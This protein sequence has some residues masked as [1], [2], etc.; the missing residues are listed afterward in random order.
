LD[1]EVNIPQALANAGGD[2]KNI[3]SLI[4]VRGE[5]W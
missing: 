4:T 1:L 3:Q 2:Y 5:L